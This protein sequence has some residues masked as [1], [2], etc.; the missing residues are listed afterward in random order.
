M[1]VIADMIGPLKLITM[2]I[3][4]YLVAVMSLSNS[5]TPASN[6]AIIGF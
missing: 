4:Y 5:I 2:A 6:K 3:G 1:L